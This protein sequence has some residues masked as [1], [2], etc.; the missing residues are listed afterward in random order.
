AGHDN[1]EAAQLHVVTERGQKI[2]ND[3]L[4]QHDAGCENASCCDDRAAAEVVVFT[5]GI[6]L[7]MDEDRKVNVLVGNTVG[8]AFPNPRVGYCQG[9]CQGLFSSVGIVDPVEDWQ[10]VYNAVFTNAIIIEALQRP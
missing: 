3:K 2:D 1:G 5:A 10:A 4:A 6:G 8:N 9:D 7:G